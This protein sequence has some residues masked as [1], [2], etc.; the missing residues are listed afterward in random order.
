MAAEPS[1]AAERY[2]ILWA[3]GRRI[4]LAHMVL[5]DMVGRCTGVMR[6]CLILSARPP[7]FVP[8]NAESLNCLRTTPG[9]MFD[10][11][12]GVMIVAEK[13]AL[14]SVSEA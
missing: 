2:H 14:P 4:L 12:R 1:H 13:N 5:Y 9:V 3:P 11:M 10:V 6:M 7:A 8:Q